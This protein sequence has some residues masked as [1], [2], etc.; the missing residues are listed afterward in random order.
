MADPQI[1]FDQILSKLREQKFRITPQRLA[2]L[3]ILASSYGHPSVEEI[4][5]QVKIDFPTTSLA[6]VY[7]TITLLKQLNEVLELGFSNIGNRYDGN[8]PY[9]HPH[10]ICTECGA[11]IDPD[12]DVI[13]NISKEIAKNTGYYITDHRLDFYGVCPECQKGK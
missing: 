4:H 1:R 13:S 10:V 7:K 6:T 3:K 9:P 11:V 12:L 5:D 8:K 2:V